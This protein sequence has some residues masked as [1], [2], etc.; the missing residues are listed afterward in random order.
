M[1]L[2]KDGERCGSVSVSVI[3]TFDAKIRSR[4]KV[5]N[6]SVD[7]DPILVMS[8]VMKAAEKLSDYIVVSPHV[9]VLRR[10]NP[11]PSAIIP[12]NNYG[13]SSYSCSSTIKVEAVHMQSTVGGEEV[14]N[15]VTLEISSG[16]YYL[17]IIA[18]KLGLKDGSQVMISRWLNCPFS[19]NK[20]SFLGVNLIK[21][22]LV[23]STGLL[24]KLPLVMSVEY[25]LPFLS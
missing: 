7:S 17:D 14:V 5:I 6:P 2:Q 23:F 16:R 20:W 10:K 4:C 9:A 19:V 13:S 12:S 11:Y 18:E 15:P 22:I 25:T 24:A 3:T 8:Y 1:S 21:T